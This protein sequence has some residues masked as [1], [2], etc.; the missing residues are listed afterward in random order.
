MAGDALENLTWSPDVTIRDN[1]FESNR[2]RGVLVSTPGRV[3]IERNRFDSSGSAILIAGDAN[4]WYESGAVRDVTI[5][6]NVFGPACLSSPYQFG[7]GIV[8]ILPEIPRPDPAYPFHRNIRIEGN[9]FH[10][11]DYPVLYAKSVD[12]LSFSDNRLIR[13]RVREP[14]HARKATLTFES[15]RRIRVE[16]NRFEGDVL[17]RNIVL[18]DTADT[19]LFV[20]PGQEWIGPDPFTKSG[21]FTRSD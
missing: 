4:Y 15:C 11:A 16:G 17:G 10:P 21:S 18:K 2:A 12:G 19:E 14:V 5:R 13:S 3:L 6:G 20:G 8:S 9:E 1:A 7:E